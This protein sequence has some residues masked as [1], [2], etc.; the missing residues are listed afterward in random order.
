MEI[1]GNTEIILSDVII[2]SDETPYAIQYKTPAENK[3]FKDL[4]VTVSKNTVNIICCRVEIPKADDQWGALHSMNNLVVRGSG[5]LSLRN[6]GGH[7]I[8]ATEVDIAGPHIYCTVEHDAIHGKKLFW[9]YGTLYITK[10]SPGCAKNWC[11]LWPPFMSLAVL[12][13]YA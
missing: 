13:F 3:G 10:A 12:S 1:I 7:G 8:R 2:V 5:Y 6:D 11:P 4:I 9:D